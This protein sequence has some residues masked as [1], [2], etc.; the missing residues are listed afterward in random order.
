MMIIVFGSSFH[1]EVA[2][3]TGLVVNW[4]KKAS[5]THT[6]LQ[7]EDASYDDNGGFPLLFHMEVLIRLAMFV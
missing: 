5:S 1:V 4:R 6:L 7:M 2:I 3:W